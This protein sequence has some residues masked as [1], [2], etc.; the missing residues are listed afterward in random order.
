MLNPKLSST[1]CVAMTSLLSGCKLITAGVVTVA[2]AVGLAGYV[3][4]KTGDIAVTGVGK[5]AQATGN[6]VSS[7]S[8]SV[9]TVIFANGDF[10][11]EE[12]QDVRTVWTASSLA[13]Q[14]ANFDSVRGTFD[15]LSGELTAKTRESIDIG[16]K[17]KSLGPQ[18]TELRIRIGVTGDMKMAELI[19]GLI[20]RELSQP[21]PTRE[22]KP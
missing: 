11:T 18:A 1:L 6:A 16:I 8:K 9:A 7:G 15:A 5:T 3:V 2:A 4:Y 14:K 17:L 19:H 10:K 13:L 12:V 21:A 22:V 20:L